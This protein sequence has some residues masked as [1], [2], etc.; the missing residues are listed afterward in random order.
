MFG[1]LVRGKLEWV[2]FLEVIDFPECVESGG[3]DGV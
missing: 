1:W 2:I 3:N